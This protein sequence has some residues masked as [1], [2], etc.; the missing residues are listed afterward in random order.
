MDRDGFMLLAMGFTGAKAFQFKM[1]Y[2]AEF[3]LIEQQYLYGQNYLTSPTIYPHESAYTGRAR[4]L[5][6]GIAGKIA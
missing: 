6:D 1:A 3:N 4:Q 2:I 5:S